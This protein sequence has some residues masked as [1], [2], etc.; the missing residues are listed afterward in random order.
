VLHRRSTGELFSSG[1]SLTR[2]GR[3]YHRT[4]TEA[5]TTTAV[6]WVDGA[7]VMYSRAALDAVGW[8]KEEYF[9]YFEDVEIGWRLRKHGYLVVVENGT[10]AYQEPGAHPTYLGIRNM[11]LFA[12]ESG[13]PHL[14]SLGSAARRTLEDSAVAVL[15]GH[16]PPLAAAWRGRRDGMRGRTGKPSHQ[17]A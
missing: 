13:I 1:G 4:A 10:K 6:D 12:R 3:A 5:E 15:H 8:L 9:L 14:R 17:P 16:L 11:T 7:I 2:G